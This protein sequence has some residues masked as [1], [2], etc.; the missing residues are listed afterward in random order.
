MIDTYSD[1]LNKLQDKYDRM[2]AS[3]IRE[4]FRQQMKLIVNKR[5]ELLDK[6]HKII[7]DETN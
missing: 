5:Q 6:M 1:E 7:L 2:G 3:D 4:T